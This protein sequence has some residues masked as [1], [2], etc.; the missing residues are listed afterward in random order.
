MALVYGERSD[1]NPNAPLFIPAAL[2]Q[3]E[4]FSPEWW[5]LVKT[6]TWFRDYWLSQHE[7]ED[8]GGNADADDDAEADDYIANMLL[9]AFDLGIV[10]ELPTLEAQPKE[11]V[12]LAEG[13]KMDAKALLRNLSV[14]R[15]HKE[16]GPKS[17]VGSA[18]YQQ[19]L[20]AKYLSPK[21]TPRQIHQP[22]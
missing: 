5:E 19:K 3:V 7:E 6:S 9:E 10:E 21:C 2:R 18:K 17:P 20:P 12:P 16:R 14:S 1:L 8:F 15:L 4:D 13:V 11:M 22:R